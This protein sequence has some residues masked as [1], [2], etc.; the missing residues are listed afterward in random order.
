[1]FREIDKRFDKIT[2]QFLSNQSSISLICKAYDYAKADV[3]YGQKQVIA[4]DLSCSP[5][6]GL[7]NTITDQ[8]YIWRLEPTLNDLDKIDLYYTQYGYPQGGK[9]FNKD[10]L[11]HRSK[12]NYIKMSSVEITRG[13]G[14]GI[15]IR[16]EG[17]RQLLA[18]LK[19]WHVLPQ[20]VTAGGNPIV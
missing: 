15:A 10:M 14:F 5:A 19:I 20:P 7:Q 13:S 8:F 3:A 4:P 12:F 11:K 17:E 16:R 1:M 18:G 9:I 2:K 6:F